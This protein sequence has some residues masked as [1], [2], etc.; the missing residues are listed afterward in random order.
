MKQQYIILPVE[1]ARQASAD[2]TRTGSKP[3]AKQFQLL[4]D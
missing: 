4:L 2:L 1:F 3:L